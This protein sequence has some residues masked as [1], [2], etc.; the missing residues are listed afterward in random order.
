[1]DSST[2][3][4]DADFIPTD[5]C[6]GLDLGNLFQSKKAVGCKAAPK[7]SDLSHLSCSNAL[8]EVKW[9]AAKKR[10]SFDRDNFE[11]FYDIDN[12]KSHHIKQYT[13]DDCLSTTKPGSAGFIRAKYNF[14]LGLLNTAEINGCQNF[15]GAYF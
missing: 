12:Q 3:V 1:M 9:E 15:I 13:Q 5:V 11:D 7:V 14:Q 4:I 6:A 10:L 8:Q 2:C